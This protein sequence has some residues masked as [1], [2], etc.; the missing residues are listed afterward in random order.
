[1]EFGNKWRNA[2]RDPLGLM[3]LPANG[4]FRLDAE[5]GKCRRA[6]KWG[7]LSGF[8]LLEKGQQTSGDSSASC[9]LEVR[10]QAESH[11]ELIRTKD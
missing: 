6:K 7:P 2:T 10:R 3:T 8:G 1:M 11:V 5:D 4:L 9:S